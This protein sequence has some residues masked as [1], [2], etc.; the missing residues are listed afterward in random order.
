[1][2]NVVFFS[3][4]SLQKSINAAFQTMTDDLINGGIIHAE[5]H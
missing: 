4:L 3:A 2:G 1:M 5:F